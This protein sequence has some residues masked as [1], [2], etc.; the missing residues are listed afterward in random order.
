MDL[1]SK[2]KNGNNM[3]GGLKN[4]KGNEWNDGVWIL[5]NVM[6]C[7]CPSYFSNF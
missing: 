7:G 1:W 5:V 2:W 6:E 3:E 4:G